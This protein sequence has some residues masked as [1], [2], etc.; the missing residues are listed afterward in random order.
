MVRFYRNIVS[1]ESHIS[2]LAA[3]GIEVIENIVR[4][5][6]GLCQGQRFPVEPGSPTGHSLP[7]HSGVSNGTLF[8]LSLIHILHGKNPPF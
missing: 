2:I 3:S 1:S 7:Y 6:L 8:F 5:G 4:R